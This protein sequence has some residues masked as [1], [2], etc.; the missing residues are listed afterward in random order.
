[1][2]STTKPGRSW[3]RFDLRALLTLPALVALLV[4][5]WQ[6]QLQMESRIEQ[7]VEKHGGDLSWNAL[8]TCANWRTGMFGAS[9]VRRLRHVRV[10]LATMTREERHE[11]IDLLGRRE[12]HFAELYEANN[13][14]LAAI[15]QSMPDVRILWIS[16]R[17]ID[18]KGLAFLGALKQISNLEVHSTSVTG[19]GLEA[20]QKLT[21]LRKL[22]VTRSKLTDSGL[23]GFPALPKLENIR[24]SADQLSSRAVLKL[25]RAK[26]L[27]SIVIQDVVVSD[28]D[29]A[30][31]FEVFPKLAVL[32][33]VIKR[34]QLPGKVPRF[35]VQREPTEC[36]QPPP[37]STLS[38][39]RSHPT[40]PERHEAR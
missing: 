2:D 28:D 20:F 13:D 7:V 21:E 3:K 23:D 19:A 9:S 27:R 26:S 18:D 14:A 37:P 22:T 25:G 40:V 16:G 32:N 8:G 12:V 33:G 24:F 31:A 10:S 38:W 5:R 34:P 17:E 15:S 11:F 39:L 30:R 36:L 1:M 4:A 29:V 35:Q 6:S